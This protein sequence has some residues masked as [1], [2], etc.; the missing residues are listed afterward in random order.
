MA[1][2]QKAYVDSLQ[3]LLSDLPGLLLRAQASSEQNAI[4]RERLQ[5]QTDASYAELLLGNLNLQLAE[6]YQSEYNK[7]VRLAKHYG[8]RG[9]I[10]WGTMRGQHF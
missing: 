7:I 6:Y 8:K 10:G 3:Q 1:Y 9:H 5:A 4:E 2:R